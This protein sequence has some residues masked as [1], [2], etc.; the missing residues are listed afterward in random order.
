MSGILPR[1]LIQVIPLEKN[2]GEHF[3]GFGP[4]GLKMYTQYESS[5]AKVAL[6]LFLSSIV[7]LVQL[8]RG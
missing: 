6:R 4:K 1:I 3:I 7:T 2:E 5:N 8:L